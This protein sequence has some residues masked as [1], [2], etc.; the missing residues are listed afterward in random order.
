MKKIIILLFLIMLPMNVYS[1]SGFGGGFGRTMSADAPIVIN[2]QTFTVS[3]PSATATQ[4]GYLT[5]EKFSNFDSIASISTTTF[6]IKAD[7]A[8]ATGTLKGRVDSNDTDIYNLQQSTGELVTSDYNIGQ[9]TGS[10]VTDVYNI[11]QST[12]ALVTVDYNIGQATGTNKTNIES[13][14]TDIYNLQQSTGSLVE[15][16]GDTMTGKLTVPEVDV[17]TVTSS[18]SIE[19]Y[20]DGESDDGIEIGVSLT[21]PNIPYFRGI[22]SYLRIG[23]TC[24]SNHGLASP[25]DLMICGKQEIDGPTYHDG[26]V[27][28]YERVNYPD[29]I[30]NF[31]GNDEDSGWRW[32]I[33]NTNHSL[34]FFTDVNSSDHS[35]NII[36]TTKDNRA[37]T[38]GLPASINPRIYFFS[39]TDWD[40]LTNE[41]GSFHHDKTNFNI[42]T[43]TGSL[44]FKWF[45]VG[46]ATM[47]AEGDLYLHDIH[48]SSGSV[49]VGTMKIYQNTSDCIGIDGGL[50]II[51]TTSVAGQ[52][53]LSTGTVPSATSNSLLL[54]GVGDTLK[55]KET[56][57][58]GG[59]ERTIVK[60]TDYD[61]DSDGHVDSKNTYAARAY[62]SGSSQVIESTTTTIITFETETFDKGSNF[63]HHTSSSIYYAPKTG[64]YS[65][66][67]KINFVP[68][69]KDTTYDV[70]LVVNGTPVT[71]KCVQTGKAAPI[72]AMVTDL[73]SLSADDKVWVIGHHLAGTDQYVVQGSSMTYF[74]I[75]YE[76][77]D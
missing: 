25:N 17:D 61:S 63:L 32:D 69:V 60:T 1:Q 77:N 41:W 8:S 18:Q 29:T 6:A 33:Y 67:A 64:I 3:M 12:G 16:A 49:Y 68:G 23:S 38:H 43:G 7:V 52:L 46:K 72:C 36:F 54:Y 28:F 34:V 26:R 4:D 55:F 58:S 27:Y 30:S 22:G 42:D 51:S 5:K 48:T 53:H 59:T 74:T 62:K 57:Q 37:K 24:T 10:L 44:V 39:A 66:R 56:S 15:K 2:A 45:G 9:A 75:N 20:P 40:S 11:G 19:I 35:G 73:I 14:D 65:V 21:S 31:V 47:T 70:G 13:N 71:Y 76:G 50:C